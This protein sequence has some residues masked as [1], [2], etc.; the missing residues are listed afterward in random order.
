[1][2]NRLAGFAI[3]LFWCIAMSWLLWHDVAPAWT[4]QD[5][6]KVVAA[7]WVNQYGHEA[8][9]GIY[10]AQG[11]NVGTIWTI[12]NTGST[13]DRRDHIYLHDFPI[14]G[15]A[16]IDIE[17]TFGVEGML[18]EI[19]IALLGSWGSIRIH[20][21]RYPSQFAFRVDFGVMNQVFK[22]DSAWA[23]IFSDMF[24]PFDTMPTLEVGQAW[25]MQ[26]FNPFAAITGVGD[27]FIPMVVRV[28]GREVIEVDGQATDCLI[29][30][31]PNARAWVDRRSGVVVVQEVELPIGGKH[32]V[33]YEPYDEDARLRAK[34]VFED[35]QKNEV[36]RSEG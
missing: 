30:E 3:I 35:I 26:V 10:N 20:G 23:G 31:A 11:R 9:F 6:P 12:Y 8:Q 34:Q 1:M 16:Y 32:T 25:R 18:D 2:V 27:P 21:E 28:V 33:R 5:P 17:S 4:A 22:I 15:A 19:D 29:V 36:K 7:D 24:R 14:L 13:T